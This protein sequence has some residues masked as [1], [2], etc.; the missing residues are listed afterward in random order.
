MQLLEDISKDTLELL[1]ELEGILK[2]ADNISV[3]TKRNSQNRAVKQIVGHLDDSA[4]NNTHRI[5]HLQYQPS[6]LIFPD[7]ANLGVNDKWI[8]I[9]DYNNYNWDDL[10]Q[11]MKYTNLHIT[12]VMKNIDTSKLQNRWISALGEEYTLE[13]MII[14]YP[15]HFKLHLDEIKDLL[16]E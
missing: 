1:D 7:Y 11:L 15:V 14:D 16:D 6:P 13:E 5:I 9:Q 2:N 8:A 4:S 3:A 10:I 12:N